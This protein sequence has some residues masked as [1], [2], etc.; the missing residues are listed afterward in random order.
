MALSLK[1]GD[2]FPSDYVLDRQLTDYGLG[3]I[4]TAT[5]APTGERRC[6]TV[7]PD[8]ALDDAAWEA[9]QADL[10]ALRGLVHENILVASDSGSEP[11]YR[12]LISPC[13]TGVR[14]LDR[15]LSWQQLK[16]VIDA[17]TYA[18]QLGIAHGHL[19]PGNLLTV[20]ANIDNIRVERGDTVSRGQTIA[21]VGAGDPAFLHFEVRQGFES[22]DPTPYIE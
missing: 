7:I 11:G 4:W 13:P 19:H 16:Q 20:Y 5:Y 9:I 2:S 1:T 12:Y 14:T 6:L 3:E 21:D 15:S 18:H 10:R 8:E 17:L 22:V